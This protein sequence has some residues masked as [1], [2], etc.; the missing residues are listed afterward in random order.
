MTEGHRKFYLPKKTGKEESAESNL[1]NIMNT[2]GDFVSDTYANDTAKVSKE[3]LQ[4][5]S[6][7]F[8]GIFLAVASAVTVIV[9]LII[10]IKY[11]FS[12]VGERANIK[13]MLIPYVVGCIVVYGSFGI[14]AL[15][16]SLLDSM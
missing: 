1:E 10:G 9:G 4:N 7:T 11:M 16:V 3:S 6:N 14:W 5:F 8:Y 12:S 15:V 2:A 13:Q